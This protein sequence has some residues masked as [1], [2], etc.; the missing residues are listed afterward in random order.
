[1]CGSAVADDAAA[2]AMGESDFREDV[3]CGD[4]G[5]FGNGTDCDDDGRSGWSE[6][7]REEGGCMSVIWVPLDVVESTESV[8]RWPGGCDASIWTGGYSL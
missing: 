7:E 8:T 5:R 3:S 1:M 2:T 4:D 6:D